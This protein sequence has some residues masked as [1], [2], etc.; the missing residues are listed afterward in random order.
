MRFLL[1]I[2]LPVLL[3]LWTVY[4]GQIEWESH[5]KQ[6]GG[7][8]D[9]WVIIGDSQAEG[10]PNTHGRLH[11]S[12]KDATDLSI[13]CQKGD[14]AY[15]LGQL[16]GIQFINHGIGGQ[17][18]FDVWR[19][20]RRDVLAQSVF[21]NK[22]IPKRTIDKKP[23]GIVVIAGINDLF[24]KIPIQDV[25]A[26]LAN[27]VESSRLNNIKCVV[28]NIPGN[29]GI[30]VNLSNQIDEINHWL[31]TDPLI[32]KHAKIVDFNSF[33]KNPEFNRND[34]PNKWVV[35]DIHLSPEGY[36]ELAK[37]VLTQP[38]IFKD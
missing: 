5:I 6:H 33:W 8:G 29:K 31:S 10:H 16:T 20:W 13:L 30:G 28:F 7:H 19:R 36:Y 9:Y 4:Q 35:D 21:F 18:T 14:L 24:A 15:F 23:T 38:N 26:N 11:I 12:D 27:M 37:F 34:E 22:N 32:I 3:V 25:K 17:T 2:S 1:L